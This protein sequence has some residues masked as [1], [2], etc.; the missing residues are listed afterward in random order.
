MKKMKLLMGANG[1]ALLAAIGSA[2]AT[3]VDLTIGGGA[4][5]GTTYGNSTVTAGA[6]TS[7]TTQFTVG[8][9]PVDIILQNLTFTTSG[10]S[11]SSVYS[12]TLGTSFT[13]NGASAAPTTPSATTGS[14]LG[15]GSL[16]GGSELI[17]DP[18]TPQTFD[19]TVS[20]Q[21]YAVTLTTDPIPASGD[22]A[23]Y[24]GLSSSSSKN[25]TAEVSV[26]AVPESSTVVSG[27]GALG[28]LILGI[29]LHSKRSVQRIG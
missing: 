14:V 29:G 24:N 23:W 11:Y 21:A 16:G 13:V 27:A 22:A 17:I 8:A 26:V 4:I 25:L 7:P 5:A 12:F 9:A 15:F 19:V 18:G 1:V 28:L 6:A 10:V 3:I 20:G 2:H